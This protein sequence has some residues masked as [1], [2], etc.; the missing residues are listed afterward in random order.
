MVA[1][2]GLVVMVAAWLRRI[3]VG[4][5]TGVLVRSNDDDDDWNLKEKTAGRVPLARL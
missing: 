4:F 3:E 5:G 2:C 1:R